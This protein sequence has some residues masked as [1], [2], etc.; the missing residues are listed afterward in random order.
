MQGAEA[1]VEVARTLENK[2]GTLELTPEEAAT[3]EL[4][5]TKERLAVAEER[6]AAIG[7]RES[8]IQLMEVAKSKAVLMAKLGARVGGRIKDAKVVGRSTL[9]YELE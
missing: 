7:L 8:Q 5:L 2:N 6:L 3:V 1:P 9:S 4:I